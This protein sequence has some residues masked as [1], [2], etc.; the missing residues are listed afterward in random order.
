MWLATAS[1]SCNIIFNMYD[2]EDDICDL[3]NA[4][5]PYS[6][7]DDSLDDISMQLDVVNFAIRDYDELSLATATV[8]STDLPLND[9]ST[10]FNVPTGPPRDRYIHILP[11]PR[12]FVQAVLERTNP[13][14][15][16]LVPDNIVLATVIHAT[17]PQLLSQPGSYDELLEQFLSFILEHRTPYVL[18]LE[19]RPL[20]YGTDRSNSMVPAKVPTTG[21]KNKEKKLKDPNRHRM[22]NRTVLKDY[23]KSEKQ[24]KKEAAK[25][26][27]K[28]QNRK[29]KKSGKG[30]D[31]RTST[32]RLL[33]RCEN[34]AQF[35]SFSVFLFFFFYDTCCCKDYVTKAA[36]EQRRDFDDNGSGGYLDGLVGC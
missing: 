11:Y 10:D 16:P 23:V 29:K 1:V 36:K 9:I 6:D 26:I 21:K 30:D 33:G 2:N 8:N 19:P 34:R 22:K 12:R 17:F 5:D 28:L 24:K 13:S 7:Y 32:F 25:I 18:P 31:V 3:N 15:N 27:K 4:T 14:S 20:V 35:T